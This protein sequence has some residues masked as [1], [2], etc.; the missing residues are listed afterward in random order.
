MQIIF[1]TWVQTTPCTTASRSRILLGRHG[2]TRTITPV[3]PEPITVCKGQTCENRTDTP[4]T[5][6]LRN[7]GAI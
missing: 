7:K 1:P 4:V 5:D 6:T 3:T 2:V